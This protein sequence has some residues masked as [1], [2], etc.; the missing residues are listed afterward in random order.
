M[1]PRAFCREPG[2]TS[3]V[4]LTFDFNPLFFERLVLPELWAGGTG[5]V[6][7]I[8]DGRRIAEASSRW[9]DQ[10]HH[11]GH[12]YQLVRASAKGTF[13]PKV[14]LRWGSEGGAVWVGSPD[15]P[16][17]RGTATE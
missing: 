3:A 14:I 11:L 5:D 13:H 2:F 7:V 10:V 16:Q 1:N 15:D 12:R 9:E 6:L 4:L 17:G 8:G